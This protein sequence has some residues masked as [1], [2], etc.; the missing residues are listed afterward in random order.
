MKGRGGQKSLLSS[1]MMLGL[2]NFFKNRQGTIALS[3]NFIHFKVV[4]IILNQS[5]ITNGV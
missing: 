3:I 1:L 5:S 4:F 2:K